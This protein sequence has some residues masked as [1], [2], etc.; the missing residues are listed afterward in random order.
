MEKYSRWR[1][2]GTQI[3]PFLPPKPALTNES[4][5]K[6]TLNTIKNYIV[7]PPIASV[8]LL[9][10]GA[11][12]LTLGLLDTFAIVLSFS[13]L[14]RHYRLLIYPV[15]L[16]PVLFFWG[17]YWIK[18][19]TVTLQKGIRKQKVADGNAVKD[20]DILVCN[21]LSYVDI[22]YLALRHAPTFVQVFGDGSVKP[23]G[24]WAAVY[25]AGSYPISATLADG[26]SGSTTLSQLATTAKL[27]SAGP[28]VVFP[29]GTTS[30][31]RGLLK[32]LPVFNGFDFEKQRIH[33]VGIKYEYESF[34]PS[35][36][37]GSPLVHVFWLCAQFA[38]FMEVR[39][40]T[41]GELRASSVATP[42]P[43]GQDA[44]SNHVA[45][46]LGQ[47]LRVRRTALGVQDKK[48]F[49]DYYKERES[50]SK[51]RTRR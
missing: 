21:S 27:N 29:E 45:G 49:L 42:L 38:N 33:T 46:V 16:R 37:V 5:A 35:Y 50:G 22:L 14:D 41:P 30:N 18:S 40:L 7:G 24:F 26:K 28:I 15:F 10:S 3:Q 11:L 47:V 13:G 9:I 4:P 2:T 32:F 48:E 1:D 51:R 36:T 23:I 25:N 20:G 17:F 8:K 6:A 39:Y 43:A 44:V 31:G 34:C 19:S 12:L